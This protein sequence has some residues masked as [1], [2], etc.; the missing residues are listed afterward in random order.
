MQ[1][2]CTAVQFIVLSNFLKMCH[3]IEKE[4]CIHDEDLCVVFARKSW[5][6]GRLIHYKED[7]GDWQ[8]E[9]LMPSNHCSHDGKT[10]PHQ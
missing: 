7:V 10:N 8:G 6:Q 4:L 9:V 3:Q 2:Y 5:R 1:R